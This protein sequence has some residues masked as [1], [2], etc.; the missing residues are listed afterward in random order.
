[1]RETA[2]V[3]VVANRTAATHRLLQVVK[4]RAQAGPWQFALRVPDGADRRAADWTT[5]R[6]CRVP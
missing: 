6:S 5:T 2:R 3:L 1:M 4:R